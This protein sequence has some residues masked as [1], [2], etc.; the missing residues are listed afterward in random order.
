MSKEDITLHTVLCHV[1]RLLCACVIARNYKP[2]IYLHK[3]ITL[4]IVK[5]FNLS[6]LTAEKTVTVKL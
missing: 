1:Y 6:F 2:V 3:D 4:F 5:N